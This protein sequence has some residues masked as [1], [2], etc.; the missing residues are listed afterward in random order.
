MCNKIQDINHLKKL[1]MK[2]IVFKIAVVMTILLTACESN[3]PIYDN[4]NGQTLVKF[5]NLAANLEI[6]IDDVGFAD[7]GVEVSTVSTADRTFGVTIDV[8]NTDAVQGS[9]SV[10]GTVTVPANSYLGTLRLDGTDVAGVDTTPKTLTLTLEPVNNVAI[11][12][13]IVIS[14]YQVCPVPA[15]FMV[16][17]YQLTNLVTRFGRSLIETRVVT[18]AAATATSRSFPNKL[19][20]GGTDSTVTLSLVCNEIIFGTV[21]ST[22]QCTAGNVIK[23]GP[24]TNNSTYGIADDSAFVVTFNFDTSNS[25]APSATQTNSS[26]LMTRI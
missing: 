2:K 14:V 3:E 24:A 19:L 21:N 11:G 18:V 15:T 13:P 1:N 7:I 12:S 22:L 26:F 9:Y 17:Q 20:G 25:C 10:P 6:N 23:Y 16:G 5:A 8:D 4:I